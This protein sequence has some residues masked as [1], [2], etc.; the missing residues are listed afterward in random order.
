MFSLHRCVLRGLFDVVQE[1]NLDLKNIQDICN[2]S[3]TSSSSSETCTWFRLGKDFIIKYHNPPSRSYLPLLDDDSLV[4]VSTLLDAS[5]VVL[6][7]TALLNEQSVVFVSECHDHLAHII[8]GFVALL[9]PLE[10]HHVIAPYILDNMMQVLEAPFPFIAGILSN[11]FEKLEYDS[12]SSLVLVFLDRDTVVAP[13]MHCSTAVELPL[14][15]REKISLSLKAERS[16]SFAS[17]NPHRTPSQIP[18]LRS[19]CLTAMVEIVSWA[20]DL[21]LHNGFNALLN[22]DPETKRF[23]DGVV[24]TQAWACFK[25]DTLAALSFEREIEL[26]LFNDLLKDTFK[27]KVVV[28]ASCI[29]IWEKPIRSSPSVGCLKEGMLVDVLRSFRDDK[30]RFWVLIAEPQGWGSVDTNDV[31]ETSNYNDQ[32]NLD[33]LHFSNEMR[34]EYL[35]DEKAKVEIQDLE[36]KYPKRGIENRYYL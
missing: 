6:I 36:N 1:S 25:Q 34:I 21:Q 8:Q 2:A 26:E 20:D 27:K 11:R 35:S 13:M 18:S 31:I 16:N 19:A 30:N 7:F 29:E 4:L 17:G 5:N 3:M 32:R 9:F 12:M 22:V 15:C 28:H 33:R 24:N 23:I 10:W 14:L